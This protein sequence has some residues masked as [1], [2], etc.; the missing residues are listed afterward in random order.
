MP[1]HSADDEITISCDRNVS[2]ALTLRSDRCWISVADTDTQY[3]E[4]KKQD[5]FFAMI[6]QMGY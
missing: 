3:P 5:T 1:K 6:P 4:V 2:Y